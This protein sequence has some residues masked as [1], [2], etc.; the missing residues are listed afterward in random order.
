MANLK[1][2]LGG[3][4]KTV[5]L[6]VSQIDFLMRINKHLQIMLSDLQ[7]KMASEYLHDLA[8]REFGMDNTKDFSFDFH[9]EKEFDNL[10]IREKINE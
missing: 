3:N 8:I 6:S 7:E 4:S 5:T 9:P 2:S 10:T 1:D